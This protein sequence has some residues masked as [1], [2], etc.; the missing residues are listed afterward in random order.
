MTPALL[1]LTLAGTAQAQDI[2]NG[3]EETAFP[4]T[5]AIGAQLGEY[6]MAV[7]TGSLITPEVVLSAAH[8]GSDYPPELV[9]QVGAAFFGSRVDNSEQ[10]VGFDSFV[11]HPDYVPLDS[12][13]SFSGSYN[14]DDLGQN[15]VAL[16]VLSEPVDVQPVWFRTEPL[17]DVAVGQTVTSVGFG[18][19]S[20]SGSGS[21]IKRSAEL[22]I[23]VISDMFLISYSSSNPNDANVC[24]GDSGGPQYHLSGDI[25]TQWSVHS[26]ADAACTSQ[27]GS[28]R[29]D[30]VSG[31]IL[32]ELEALYGT[33]DRC[34]IWDIY[35]D[36]ICDE[37]CDAPDPDCA[38]DEVLDT[39]E[40]T[41]TPP[42]SGSA[43]EAEGCACS[44]SSGSAPV[45]TYLLLLSLVCWRRGANRVE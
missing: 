9:V 21:G 26:W 25:W 6:T 36:G 8:C 16:L 33:R 39:G 7:C 18:V 45:G 40:P 13:G 32:D 10:I 44:S 34:E 31:W 1:M 11:V 29:T 27:S 28:T 38:T 20:G 4:A 22:Q 41:V 17:D 14:W 24:S 30:V 43:E 37:D 42:K 3:R 35:D 5:V 2:V 19:T 23:D 12:G 15:D